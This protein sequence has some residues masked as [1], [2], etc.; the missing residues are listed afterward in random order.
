MSET[1]PAAPFLRYA[2][3]AIVIDEAGRT[4]LFRVDVP[5]PS[6]RFVW[7]TPGGGI[8]EGELEPDCVRREVFEETGLTEFELGPCVWFRDQTFP[9][10]NAMIRQVESY[11]V[12][13]TAAF[14]V[15]IAGQEELE[16][17]YLTGHRWF[18]LEEL[19]THDE[20]LAPAN[21]AELLEPLLRGEYPAEPLIVGA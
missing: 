10:G 4:L 8:D 21:F 11:Y 14:E 17:G 16:R 12:V 19:R 3:R 13:R 20:P 7:I 15:N 6:T 1:A 18:T 5:G 2:A 9:W